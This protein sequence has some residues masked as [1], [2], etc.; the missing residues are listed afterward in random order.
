MGLLSNAS[1]YTASTLRKRFSFPSKPC[2]EA[3]PVT[4]VHPPGAVSHRRD[5]FGVPLSPMHPLTFQPALSLI[6]RLSGY[7]LR[8][9]N[10]IASPRKSLHDI[11][12][13]AS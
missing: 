13:T 10:Y 2:P 12:T 8:Y 4:S 11:R 6:R 9:S 1:E 3:H 7:P 5:L